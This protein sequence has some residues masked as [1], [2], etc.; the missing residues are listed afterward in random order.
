MQR[1]A[2]D[3]VIRDQRGLMKVGQDHADVGYRRRRRWQQ[4]REFQTGEMMSVRGEGGV[5]LLTGCLLFWFVLLC[6]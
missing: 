3:E 2:R 6:K 5:R 1:S 4:T